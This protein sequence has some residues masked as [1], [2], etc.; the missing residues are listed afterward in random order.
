MKLK[1][2]I[3]EGYKIDKDKP[4]FQE[5]V[6][7]K[8]LELPKTWEEAFSNYLGKYYRLGISCTPIACIKDAIMIDGQYSKDSLLHEEDCEQHL[9]LMQLHFLRD[10]YRQGWVP[11]WG[12]GSYKK[13][14]IVFRDSKYVVDYYY[15]SRY[16]LSFET[17]ELAQKFLD[18]FEDLI[19]KTGDLI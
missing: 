1:I 8:K 16:F 9:A 15:N 17:K 19:I 12:E 3:P 10:I 4:T 7:K 2:E 18:H 14:C 11:G 5:I 13:W 6:F